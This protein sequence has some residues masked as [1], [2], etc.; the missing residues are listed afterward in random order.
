MEHIGPICREW[1]LSKGITQAHVATV[2]GMQ[3]ATVCRFEKGETDSNRLLF[4]YIGLGF[5]ATYDMLVRYLGR[6]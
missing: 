6:T 2:A 1:R 3:R 4:T 5:P